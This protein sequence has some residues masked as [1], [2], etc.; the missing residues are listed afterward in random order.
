MKY[1]ISP[2]AHHANYLE[3]SM[4]MTINTTTAEIYLPA[5][6]PGR[7]QMQ[8]FAKNVRQFNAHQLDGAPLQ[9][10]K[11]EKDCWKI[12]VE[13]PQVVKI[14]YE[15]YA[16]Q[17]DAGGSY[18]DANMLYVNPINCCM[19]AKEHLESPCEATLT[20]EKNNRVACGLPYEKAEDRITFKAKDF[21]QLVDTSI[22]IS[23]TLQ[24]KTYES[25]G[26]LFHIWVQGKIE[27][28]WDKVLHNFKLFTDAQIDVFG[29]FPEATY[30]FMLWVPAHPYY[31]GVEHYNS[32][33]MVLGPDS[34]RFEEMYIDL[35]GLASHELFHTW[36]VKRIRP[37][38]LLPYRYNEENYFETCFVSEGLT[39]FYGDWMLYRS[40]VFDR[41]QF[42]KELE[43]TLKRHFDFADNSSLSLLESS[44]DLWLDG[45]EAGAPNRKVSVYHK[46]AVA[47]ILLNEILKN[48]V[49]H[50][51]PLDLI[52]QTLWSRFGKPYLGFTYEDY[53]TIVQ[54]I[55]KTDSAI[56]FKTVIE[57]NK[58][59][60][61]DVQKATENLGFILK[62]NQEGKVYLENG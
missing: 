30:H 52:M 62:K 43:T 8:H 31:H 7:Y 54:E 15:Y 51:F 35:L 10:H 39:T 9:W 16:N 3:I 5:W 58:S 37:L 59:L 49:D 36:N 53:C 45:Y 4:E 17:K 20:F 60:F 33:M 14:S 38:E 2:S 47:A 46:G 29:E 24:H 18:F 40:G 55:V 26:V 19:Y 48:H 32:T 44:Y 1:W 27:I 22:I 13:N 42:Q 57:G 61:D 50:D 41:K 56:Y 21:H 11:I 28:D 25:Y 23:N 12:E 6:R 34:Q